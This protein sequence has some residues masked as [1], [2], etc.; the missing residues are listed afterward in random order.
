MFGEFVLIFVLDLVFLFKIISLVLFIDFVV[1]VFCDCDE[2]ELVAYSLHFVLALCWICNNMVHVC[3]LVHNWGIF[4]V[5]QCE[6]K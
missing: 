6:V 1:V 5:G 4:H 2:Q 3:L